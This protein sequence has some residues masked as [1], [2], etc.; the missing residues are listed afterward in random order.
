MKI[1][2][3]PSKTKQKIRCIELDETYENI[4][5]LARLLDVSAKSIYQCMLARDG[6][7]NGRHFE[8]LGK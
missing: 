5:E 4:S 7:Y 3:I 2:R 8:F 6:K 1:F